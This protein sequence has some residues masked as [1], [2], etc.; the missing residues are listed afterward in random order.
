ML[1]I[2]RLKRHSIA[3]Y[4]DT[5]DAAKQAAMDRQKANGGL[6]EYYSEGETRV[7][8]WLVVGDKDF[9]GQATGLT[10]AQLEGGDA[11]TEA[12]RI[13]L[14]DGAAPNGV[15]GRAFTEA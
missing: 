5:A 15:H 4:N 2:S 10:Q 3:Y 8:T 9:I 6:A 7:P 12:A 11:D 1:T 14:D 13:W